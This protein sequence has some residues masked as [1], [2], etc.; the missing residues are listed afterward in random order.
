MSCNDVAKPEDMPVL[1]IVTPDEVSSLE[2]DP[3][4][5]EARVQAK[6]IL[7][8]VKA[9]GKDALIRQAV[10]LGDLKSEDDDLLLGTEEMKE[11]FDALPEEDREVLLRTTERVKAFALAQRASVGNASAPIHGGRAGH[12]ISPVATAGCYAPGG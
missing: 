3:V 2:L 10:R 12:T 9:G 1:K 7:D 11:A 6:G 5:P 8:D 4:D